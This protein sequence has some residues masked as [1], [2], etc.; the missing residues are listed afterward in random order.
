MWGQL[1]AECANMDVALDNIHVRK[2]KLNYETFH[3]LT[4]KMWDALC[5]FGEMAV[6]KHN[7]EKFQAKMKNKGMIVMML[8]YAEN[9]PKGN[10]HFL[11]LEINL[12]IMS[13]DVTWL[14]CYHGNHFKIT[15]KERSIIEID[16][17]FYQ[18][19]FGNE[20]EEQNQSTKRLKISNTNQRR[21]EMEEQ[22]VN[23]DNM[24]KI[25]WLIHEKQ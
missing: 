14:N 16:P 19:Y 3:S 9:H 2:D 22:E 11:N 7:S 12:I 13:Q 8:G 18:K 15:Q 24:T 25:M 6:M 10:Y 21:I 23:H 17:D 5:A 1:W 4:P 20:D